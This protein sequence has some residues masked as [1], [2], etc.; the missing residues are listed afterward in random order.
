MSE[1]LLCE[2]EVLNKMTWPCRAFINLRIK[3]DGFPKPDRCY[4]SFGDQWR[5]S[6]ID[7]WLGDPRVIAINDAGRDFDQRFGG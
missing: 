6:D 4:S 5:E 7:E 3:R 2:R 1:R